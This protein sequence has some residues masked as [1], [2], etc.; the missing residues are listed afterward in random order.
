MKMNMIE[1]IAWLIGIV[2]AMSGIGL[3]LLFQGK[4][5]LAEDREEKRRWAERMKRV[6]I[7][8]F[9]IGGFYLVVIWVL[10]ALIE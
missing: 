6:G 3:G 2:L 8:G 7:A 9:V 10:P 1:L 4:Y 5:L